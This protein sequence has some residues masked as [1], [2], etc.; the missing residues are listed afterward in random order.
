M[1]KKKTG[2]LRAKYIT[3]IV[4]AVALTIIATQNTQTTN[5]NLLFWD[6]SL[7]LILLIGVAFLAGFSMGYIICLVKRRKKD[8]SSDNDDA[9]PADTDSP[10]KKSF[11]RKKKKS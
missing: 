9:G 6:I 1:E 2:T 10:G 7:S 4:I 3:L 5:V 11:F 8:A